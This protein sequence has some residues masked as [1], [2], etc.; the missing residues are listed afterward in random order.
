[1]KLH[2]SQGAAARLAV[3]AFQF[4]VAI[5]GGYFGAGIGIL[6]LA[7][8]PFICP[9]DIH[10]MNAIKTF[11]AA[12]INGCSILVFVTAGKVVW[13]YALVMAAA[14]VAGGYC[15]AHFGRLLPR[16]A[17][18]WFVIGAGFTITAVQFV[19]QLTPATP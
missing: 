9:G 12:C 11:L 6:M 19:K 17:V 5:Y 1:M 4:V 7:A 14:G 10:R 18:R 2:A 15:G 13:K 3:A 8:L 16:A